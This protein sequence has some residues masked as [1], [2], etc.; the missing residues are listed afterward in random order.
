MTAKNIHS[1]A[2]IALGAGGIFLFGFI[3]PAMA[4]SCEN[5]IGEF[6]K[7]RQAQME[8]IAKLQKKGEGK[9]D[10]VAAC[11]ILRQLA[12]AEQGMLAYM[13]KNQNWCNIP[14]QVLTNVKEGTG[15]TSSI[16]KQACGLA[17]QVKKQQQQ[18]AAGAG[19]GA[20]GFNV[21]ASK[22]PAGPL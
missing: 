6:Q 13:E 14:D 7:K 1:L 10:P 18:Q 9:L 2:R 4:Q 11:P 17:A 3:A 20:P 8:N 12:S 19:A 16:T 15:K 21:K 5:D 22:L